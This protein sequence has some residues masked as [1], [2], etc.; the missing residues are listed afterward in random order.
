MPTIVD[1]PEIKLIRTDTTLDLS[2]KAE[3][4]WLWPRPEILKVPQD[5]AIPFMGLSI[6][7]RQQIPPQPRN[8]APFQPATTWPNE[9]FEK[10]DKWRA[11]RDPDGAKSDRLPRCC[12]KWV[13]KETNRRDHGRISE[14]RCARQLKPVQYQSH[15]KSSTNDLAPA[16]S[17]WCFTKRYYFRAEA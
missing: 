2:Q 10:I 7:Q 17:N 6:L 14:Y 1:V 8:F 12:Q 3:K 13:K 9:N 4:V 16:T 11:N 5:C 15:I